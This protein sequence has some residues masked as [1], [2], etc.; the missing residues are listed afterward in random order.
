MQKT[1][2]ISHPN[3]ALVLYWGKRNPE[4]FLPT[5]SSLSMTLD[6]VDKPLEYKVTLEFS[7]RYDK[8]SVFIDGNELD[9]KNETYGEFIRH[10]NILRH[11]YGPMKMWA[12]LSTSA[13]FPV[14]SGLAGS[15]ARAAAI[16][17]AYFSAIEMDVDDRIKSSA[18]RR[19]SGSGCR[20]INGG[21]NV[22]HAYG[23]DSNSFAVQLYP[24]AYWDIRDVIAVANPGPK[25]VPSRLGMETTV[26]TCPEPIY[27]NFV[28]SAEPNIKLVK[29][30][31]Q[32][33]N[34][35]IVGSAYEYEN[36]LFR[37]V[38]MNTVPSLNYWSTATVNVF[39]TIRELQEDGVKVYGGTDAGPNVHILVLPE[40]VNKVIEKVKA[41]DGV[42][43]LIHCKPGSGVKTTNDH[44]F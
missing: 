16:S 33:K 40:D 23:S 22:W 39:N 3:K 44:L 13:N 24:E 14:G 9:R 36:L 2:V 31:L 35:S 21:F 37:S 26:Q 5:R 15:A 34:L 4:L 43:D 32:T 11:D 17:A 7:D 25:K 38:C 27:E 12:R 20:S 29:E 10:L 1:T 8:D 18:A 41:I 30:G 28:N 6:G 42:V 19:G